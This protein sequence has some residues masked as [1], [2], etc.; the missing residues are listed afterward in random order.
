MIA[1]SEVV[2]M[3]VVRVLFAVMVAALVIGLVGCENPTGD[4]PG[5][6]LCE[7][8]NDGQCDEPYLCPVGTDTADCT[9]EPE[10]DTAPSFGGQTVADQT[11]TLGEAI[12]ALTPPAA[13][14]GNG[15]LSYSLRPTVPGLRFAAAT[16]TLNGTPTSAGTYNMV[17]TVTDAAGADAS[18]RFTITVRI[19][20]SPNSCEYANDGECDEATYCLVGTD[21]ADC[22]NALM[23]IRAELASGEALLLYLQ[24]GTIDSFTERAIKA[25]EEAIPSTEMDAFVADLGTL[26]VGGDMSEMLANKSFR[27]LLKITGPIYD[28]AYGDL[29]PV[30]YGANSIAKAVATLSDDPLE[31]YQEEALSW[32]RTKLGGIRRQLDRVLDRVSR[33]NWQEVAAGGIVVVVVCGGSGGVA[34][35]LALGVLVGWTLQGNEPSIDDLPDPLETVFSNYDGPSERLNVLADEFSPCDSGGCR[36]NTNLDSAPSS[37]GDTDN[38]CEY[39]N[40]GECDEGTYCPVGTDTADCVQSDLVRTQCVDVENVRA[41][42]LVSFDWRRWEWEFVNNCGESVSIRW[43]TRSANI[44]WSG[45]G[46]SLDVGEREKKTGLWSQDSDPPNPVTVWCAWVGNSS[47]PCYR[48][49]DYQADPTN[50]REVHY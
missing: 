15:T 35:P 23:S 7:Y 50:W 37:P 12:N 5:E 39:A 18:L 28:S 42:Y 33:P 44:E 17:Y 41:P 11:Y 36:H 45:W 24:D 40:D 49:N 19:A 8:E 31:Q 22:S 25:V 3:R 14:G 30:N 47:D 16:R 46:D 13:S 43:N 27:R 48:E 34:C 20:P 32:L 9:E 1:S 26:R 29:P 38:S 21:T 10:A 6:P 4:E 2:M